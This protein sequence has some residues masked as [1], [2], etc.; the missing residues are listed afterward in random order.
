M[1]E[2]DMNYSKIIDSLSNIIHDVRDNKLSFWGGALLYSLLMVVIW[3]IDFSGQQKMLSFAIEYN[4][5]VK[6]YSFFDILNFPWG[7]MIDL[8]LPVLWILFGGIIG[9][10]AKK[11]SVRNYAHI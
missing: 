2:T 5:V 4:S 10:F 6:H 1:Q 11:G 7:G 3:I 8:F 9:V